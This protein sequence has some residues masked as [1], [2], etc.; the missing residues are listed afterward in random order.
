MIAVILWCYLFYIPS[1]CHFLLSPVLI[2]ILAVIRYS[3][4]TFWY[5]LLLSEFFYIPL[6]AVILWCYISFLIYLLAIILC[7]HLCFIIY[8]LASS[9]MML[10]V[11]FIYLPAFIIWCYLCFMIY[12]LLSGIPHSCHL[13][14]SSVLK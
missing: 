14:L 7:C 4:L 9:I 11:F 12:L 5:F 6:I 2:Y 1:N 10:S 13:L 8:L 3:C